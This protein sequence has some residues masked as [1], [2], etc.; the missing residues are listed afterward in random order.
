MKSFSDNRFD[1]AT[2]SRRWFAALLWRAF[3][4]PSENVVAE[5]A[6]RALG[7]TPRQVRNWLRCENSAALQYVTAVMLIAGVEIAIG[8]RQ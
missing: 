6:A 1:H 4:G 8:G 7:V 5:A 2:A 3:P